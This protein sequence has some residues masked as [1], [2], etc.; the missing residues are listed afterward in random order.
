MRRML[1]LCL[2]A[3]CLARP[4]FATVVFDPTVERLTAAATRIVHGIVASNEVIPDGRSLTTVT[5]I[6]V[7]AEW[8]TKGAVPATVEVR[9]PGGT[10]SGRHV[11]VP[12]AAKFTVGEEVVVFLQPLPPSNAF[13]TVAL[14][15]AKF[16]LDRGGGS[17]KVSRALGDV[18]VMRP[19]VNG[20]PSDAASAPESPVVL[21]AFEARV[22]AAVGR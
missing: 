1:P 21:S 8:K 22:R 3:I 20:A 11:E 16:S 5:Q 4:V 7:I 19:R 6:R 15:A 12:G 2:F 13:T 18:A 17:P 9:Q 10:L 14:S